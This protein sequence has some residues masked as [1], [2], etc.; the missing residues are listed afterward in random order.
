MFFEGFEP[1]PIEV[2]NKASIDFSGTESSPRA[3]RIGAFLIPWSEE[4]EGACKCIS[5]CQQMD[6]KQWAILA[7]KHVRFI[8]T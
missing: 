1:L 7:P 5:H 6:A 8:P 4:G 2:N 3:Q